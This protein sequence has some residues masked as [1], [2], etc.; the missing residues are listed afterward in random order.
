MP[1]G[2]P[3]LTSL[4]AWSGVPDIGLINT[5]AVPFWVLSGMKRGLLGGR[6][7]MPAISARHCSFSA[8]NPWASCWSAEVMVNTADPPVIL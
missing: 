3:M 4:C 2:V 7:P 6:G 5:W 1:P 8:S